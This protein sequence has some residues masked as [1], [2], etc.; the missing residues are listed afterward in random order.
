MR[1][2]LLEDQVVLDL[3]AEHDVTPAQVVLRWH[4]ELGNVV[5]TR[6]VTPARIEENYAIAGFTL[7]EEAL[8]AL[9]GPRPGHPHRGRPRHL[10]LSGAQ[11]GPV[12]PVLG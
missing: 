4:I 2:G 12:R 7:G 1:A 9:S 3:A 11:R 5:L 8:E 6:S 10:R